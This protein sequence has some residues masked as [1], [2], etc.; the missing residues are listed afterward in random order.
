MAPMRCVM[1]AIS[2]PAMAVPNVVYP[3]V[4]MVSYSR[5][6]PVMMAMTTMGTSVQRVAHLPAVVTVNCIVM[7]KPV[8]MAIFKIGMAAPVNASWLRAA[9]RYCGWISRLEWT[10]LKSVMT[11]ISR[12]AM[13]APKPAK[14]RSVAMG[15]SRRELEKPATMA[16]RMHRMPVQTDVGRLA[17]GTSLCVHFWRSAMMVTMPR[18]MAATHNANE[19][20]VAMAGSKSALKSAMM[21]T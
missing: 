16:I 14:K 17:V 19:K 13:V 21:G 7:R 9:M 10:V 2:T 12:T 3:L 8:T 15:V 18:G 4:V 6:K 1:M 20:S 5:A 11:A